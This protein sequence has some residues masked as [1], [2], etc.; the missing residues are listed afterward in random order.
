MDVMENTKAI[1][2]AERILRHRRLARK[3]RYA[4]IYTFQNM[5]IAGLKINQELNDFL[6]TDREA[7]LELKKV[8]TDA[9]DKYAA[10]CVKRAR[11]LERKQARKREK[12]ASK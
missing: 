10:R 7:L 9:A 1:D 2:R 3:S 4:V 8:L 12:E 5:D 6:A 11:D